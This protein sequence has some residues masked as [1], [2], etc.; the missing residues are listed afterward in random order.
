MDKNVQRAQSADGQLCPP[1]FSL[2]GGLACRSPDRIPRPH[3]HHSAIDGADVEPVRDER[4]C[5]APSSTGRR[6]GPGIQVT[7]A[8]ERGADRGV[9]AP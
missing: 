4:A 8:R 7:A 9:V 1:A 2:E 3:R 6:P 5:G